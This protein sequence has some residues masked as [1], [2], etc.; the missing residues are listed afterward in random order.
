MRASLVS[1]A[2][3]RQSVASL[4]VLLAATMGGCSSQSD[5]CIG[6]S[7]LSHGWWPSEVK[8]SP[9]PTPDIDV[10]DPKR[11]KGKGT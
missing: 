3:A 10:R 4:L 8:R 2:V 11:P 9:K 5:D 6:R 1:T 7:I